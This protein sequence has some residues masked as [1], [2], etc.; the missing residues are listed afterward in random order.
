MAAPAQESD[1]RYDH[2]ED[3]VDF[4]EFSIPRQLVPLHVKVVGAPDGDQVPISQLRFYCL[5][6]DRGDWK[7]A[8]DALWET[9]RPAIARRYAQW[10][11]GGWEAAKPLDRDIVKREFGQ[12]SLFII[13]QLVLA[14]VTMGVSFGFTHGR[15]E[16]YF[17]A[18][19]ASLPLRKMKAAP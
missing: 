1:A 10:T 13:V 2:H 7:R 18:V 11:R 17:R 9:V 19:S 16:F 14:V 12:D 3:V 4:R 15:K 5:S 6:R 8:E